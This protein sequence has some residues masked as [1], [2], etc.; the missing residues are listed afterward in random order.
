MAKVNNTTQNLK[1]NPALLLGL[2][3]LT[4][5]GAAA[6]LL[7]LKSAPKMAWAGYLLSFWYV[8]AL[9]MMAT[10]F[11]GIFSIAKSGW[12][13]VFKRVLEGMSS[14]MPVAGVLALGIVIFGIPS[15]YHW[16]DTAHVAHDAV[17]LHKAPFLNVPFFSIRV[18]IYFAIWIGFA[19]LFIKN[20][21]AQDIDG[22]GER[23]IKIIPKSALFLILFALSYSFASFD[24]IMSVEPHWFSTMYGV[25]M[26]AG[27][28]GSG[29]AMLIL[30]LAL[31]KKLGFL[32]EVNENHFHNIAQLLIGFTIFW[33]YIWF[34]Q[35]MLIWYANIPEETMFFIPRLTNGWELVLAALII[36]K[37]LLPFFMLLSRSVKRSIKL[38]V[39]I[40]VI[41]LISQFI[42]IFY[43]IFPSILGTAHAPSLTLNVVLMWVGALSFFTLWVLLYLSRVNLIAKNDP[44]LEES[45][46]LKL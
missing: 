46:K 30:I 38:L 34:S 27:M 40:S 42:D 21:L 28:M 20:S 37:W 45:M 4:V 35:F 19:V 18:V 2:L 41:I 23:T 24:F 7:Q 29:L 6:F 12:Q 39:V 8:L 17:L 36:I 16:A 22:K 25:Y 32:P 10:V 5:A 44:L 31:V 14:F 13:V 1:I 33:M 11:T 9:A 43:N 15:L 26:F 3:A